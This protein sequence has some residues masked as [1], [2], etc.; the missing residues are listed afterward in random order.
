MALSQRFKEDCDELPILQDA[1]SMYHPLFGK[2]FPLRSTPLL[3]LR[4]VGRRIL[5]TALSFRPLK[6]PFL[7]AT[8]RD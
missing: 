7:R 8:T 3:K 6:R 4:C 5:I 1:V 2:T